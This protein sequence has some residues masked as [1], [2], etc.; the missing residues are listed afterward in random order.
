MAKRKVPVPTLKRPPGVGGDNTRI[1]EFDLYDPEMIGDKLMEL[2]EEQLSLRILYKKMIK[3]GGKRLLVKPVDVPDM[4]PLYDALPNFKEPLLD[5]W[6]QMSL[7]IDTEDAIEIKPIL[8]VGDPGIGKTHFAKTLAAMLRTYS[9]FIQMNSLTAGFIIGGS[10]AEWKGARQGKI[11]NTLLLNQFAN[12]V[13]IIDEIDKAGK[14]TEYDPLGTLYTLLERETASDFLDEYADVP[15]NAS[16]L[17]YVI[18]ANDAG[19]I[20]GPILDRM[21]VYDIRSPDKQQCRSIAHN[22]YVSLHKTHSWGEFFSNAP[23]EEV[24]DVVSKHSPRDM[25]DMWKTAFA[26]ARIAKRKTIQA[27]DI[28][29]PRKGRRK[30]GF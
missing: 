3:L 20:P 8:L 16:R 6:R 27:A 13:V 4:G 15:I 12:P 18:T 30:I 7:C 17:T 22:I 1:R 10:S 5:I 9:L 14:Q 19:Y 25:D 23:S 11:F 21:N 24:L 26:N 2:E 28:L 29:P